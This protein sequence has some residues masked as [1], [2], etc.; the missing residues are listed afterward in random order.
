MKIETHPNAKLEQFFQVVVNAEQQYALWPDS[1][2]RPAGWQFTG[3]AGPREACLE[4]VRTAWTDMRPL[5]VR[6]VS[7]G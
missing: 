5:S 6:Q 2:P 7:N 3:Q 1:L 4:W